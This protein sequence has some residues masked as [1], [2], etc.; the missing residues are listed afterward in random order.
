MK[1]KKSEK[2]VSEVVGSI[3][4]LM[5][6]I[7][8]F[9]VVMLWVVSYP[10]PSGRA[11]VDLNAEVN[12][13]YV[14]ISHL[15]GEALEN[16]DTVIYVYINGSLA[17]GKSYKIS[18]ADNYATIG[19]SFSVGETWSKLF[20]D[21]NSTSTVWVTIVDTKGNE[22][23]F[24]KTLQGVSG[25]NPPVV[26]FACTVPSSVPADGSTSFKV[27]AYIL[28]PDKDVSN[29]TVD[30]SSVGKSTYSMTS[31]DG[32]IF[33]T[34]SLVI[35]SGIS[36]GIYKFNIINAT[37]SNGNIATGYVQITVTTP[38]NTTDIHDYFGWIM[39]DDEG[40][41]GYD[42]YN[43][44]GLVTR[45]GTRVFLQGETIYMQVGSLTLRIIKI[46]N[47][48]VLYNSSF[49]KLEPQTREYEPLNENY[50]EGGPL[51][52]PAFYDIATPNPKYYMYEYNCTAPT[53]AGQYLV[54]AAI[55]DTAGHNFV[56][57][58]I[59]Y[60]CNLDGSAPNYPKIVT[61]RDANADGDLSDLY[62]ETEFKHTEKMYVKVI[63]EDTNAI[64][65]VEMGDVEINNFRGTWHIK[66]NLGSPP[67]SDKPPLSAVFLNSKPSSLG[68][69][70]R[71]DGSTF[72]TF[73]IALV[74]PN[75]YGW[76]K[77]TNTYVL[78]VRYFKDT[79][80]EYG[81]LATLVKVKGPVSSR[82]VVTT[83]RYGTG[84]FSSENAIYW[85]NNDEQWDRTTVISGVSSG[86]W[87]L[88]AVRALAVG[89][90][91][92]D[93]D[94]DIVV[95]TE[96]DREENLAWFENVEPD[97]S[98]WIAHFVTTAYGGTNYRVESLA[99]ADLD[100]DGDCEII[101]G[102]KNKD[103]ESA[104]GTGVHIYVNDGDWT[105][106]SLIPTDI[107]ACEPT[108]KGG[109]DDTN[110]SLGNITTDNSIYYNVSSVGDGKTFHFNQWNVSGID[111]DWDII[112]VMLYTQ[113]KT[114]EGYAGD[115]YIQ[116]DNGAGFVNTDIQPNTTL[117]EVIESFDLKSVGVD[118]LSEI[119]NLDIKFHNEPSGGVS[120]TVKPSSKGSSDNSTKI[121][122]STCKPSSYKTTLDNCTTLSSG[123]V[124]DVASSQGAEDTTWEWD[125]SDLQPDDGEQTYDV[126][127]GRKMHLNAFDTTTNPLPSGATI[128]LTKLMCKWKVGNSYTGTDIVHYS[129][130]NGINW[131]DTTIQPSSG[132]TAFVSDSY[133][134]KDG[135][136]PLTIDQI[137][138]LDV[139]FTNE[140]SYSTQSK[141]Y[142]YW[143]YIY[144]YVGYTVETHE[145]ISDIQSNDGTT[146][147]VKSGQV[148]Y[149]E[150]FD[151]G[152][153]TG[154]VKNAVLEVKYK[155]E[156]GSYNGNNYIRWKLD[157]SEAL[158]NTTIIPTGDNT[159]FVTRYYDLK[160]ANGGSI[161]LSEIQNLDIEFTNNAISD[162]VYFD[163]IW[164]NVS[165]EDYNSL[166]NIKTSN[167]ETYD[168][169]KNQ[170]LFMD[171]FDTG[172]LGGNVQ[173]ATLS[174]KYKV[175]SGYD[176][177]ENVTWALDGET[178]KNTTIKPLNTE[179][180]YMWKEFDLKSAN[181]GAITI[182]EL[183]TLDIRF[184][185]NGETNAQ[186]MFDTLQINVTM[187]DS[188]VSFDYVWIKVITQKPG[189]GAI[190]SEIEIGDL[191][192]SG[193]MDVVRASEDGKTVIYWN[194][195][196]KNLSLGWSDTELQ[197]VSTPSKA[198]HLI[199][200]GY[201]EDA[202]DTTLDI[203][204]TNAD[205]IY[206]F[207]NQGNKTFSNK[208]NMDSLNNISAG[209]TALAAGDMNGDGLTDITVGTA[210]KS[211]SYRPELWQYNRT[212]WVRIK[213]TGM[214]N[215]I[216]WTGWGSN[217]P[218][219]TDIG[220]GDI[221]GDGDNDTVIGIHAVRWWWWRTSV[222]HN[223][224]VYYNNCTITTFADP[225]GE[226]AAG[227]TTVLWYE[228]E[229]IYIN[230]WD[231]GADES[232]YNIELG[233]I[234]T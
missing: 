10:T 16:D 52:E 109:N 214:C 89:D 102:M 44:T 46:Q 141:Y 148:L 175:A 91:D 125:T 122:N 6:T 124:N 13:Q 181:G 192:N 111:P 136:N 139:N 65:N 163:Y 59:I 221:D 233:Y 42:I 234:D 231:E 178:Q 53:T 43:E 38:A 79:N 155:V 40:E 105:D 198:R 185:N 33:K 73:S 76:L 69:D 95:G 133:E 47:S 34:S 8:M 229:E 184:I 225:D 170:I 147:D 159:S 12:G 62:E 138:A 106:I 209:I 68:W 85:Y 103:G 217:T 75:Q 19:D 153:L 72:Y 41:T 190:V 21:I 123:S 174:V 232:V 39:E 99:L 180:S 134:L 37:D 211:S 154:T 176:G 200:L 152:S 226:G 167:N 82:D 187:P 183:Y 113:Y 90:I 70:G 94:N 18:D 128:T 140:G 116:Y 22:V 127:R 23:I 84:W 14:N 219:V 31:A 35:A 151:I 48:F 67:T 168:V 222:K 66:K 172:V 210:S 101:A 92:G 207:K 179:T 145:N 131:N 137:A 191:D 71:G 230:P 7:T 27:Y 158:Q 144:V 49:E 157:G 60:V 61:C 126:Y 107:D 162:T 17:G 208:I 58:D 223:L 161:T 202:G 98:D 228:E 2:G 26:A 96:D 204:R 88:Q 30:L 20:L 142:V 86:R 165:V 189:T 196:D 206:L 205:D 193:T 218:C 195:G 81:K 146:Y 57:W 32:I 197:D 97:G 51:D 199:E 117:T 11:Y 104:V 130:D 55:K 24:D 77:G 220:I 135:G 50:V 132:Q 9:A 56:T 5:I 93:G 36:A 83:A 215:K 112:S 64:E 201:F 212:T 119:Q 45:V 28:D 108:Q 80:E 203:L 74:N 166:D 213:T 227:I 87:K 120:V 194:D 188:V 25:N 186:V 63:T 3:L 150:T 171:S 78:I 29:V 224:W 54:Y 1:I 216:T 169:W 143:D 149:M 156:S 121:T 115:E 182:E 110:Q 173:N 15:G 177:T 114:S 164:I 4:I 129:L 100:H 118:T 160:E